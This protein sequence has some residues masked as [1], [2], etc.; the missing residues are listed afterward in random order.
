MTEA[1]QK[2]GMSKGCLIGL[3]VAGVLLVMIIVA[4]LVLW[5]YWEDFTKFAGT[6]SVTGVK[7]MVA[8][9]PPPGLDTVSFNA[10][11]DGFTEKFAQE[12]FDTEKSG[13]F[14]T[15]V[16]SIASDRKVDSVEAQLFLEALF[17]YYPE[18]QDL[19]PPELPDTAMVTD[20]LVSE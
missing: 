4:A 3:I 10:V 15:T 17:D 2:K 11:C 13:A 6:T 9:N 8:V 16:Q 14:F 12:E 19:M 20:S 1:V 5:I 18:L 7:T